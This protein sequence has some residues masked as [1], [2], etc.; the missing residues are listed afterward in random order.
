MKR[1]Y[2]FIALCFC[3]DNFGFS[4]TNKY[5][6]AMEKNVYM[7]DTAM[8]TATYL[9]LFHNFKRIADIEKDKWLPLYYAGSCAM[10]YAGGTEDL[11]IIEQW[12]DVAEEY[13]LKADSLSPQNP[14]I[15]ILRA[16]NLFIK[17]QVDMMARGF[18]YT[19][20]SANLLE[21][22]KKLDPKN[23]RVYIQMGFMKYM[24]PQQFGGDKSK[25]CEFFHKA[26]ELLIDVN[27][28]TIDVHWGKDE[29]AS[30]L[31]RCQK[32]ADAVIKTGEK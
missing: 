12:T 29:A 17:I 10:S 28:Q 27:T 8:K 20:K 15:M 26:E 25:A 1:I 13:A 18:N 4:Q 7:L 24:T 5:Q 16:S 21:K 19:V 31:R 3:I 30:M 9:K 14:E 11:N 32:L 2:L 23:P 6:Q 22:A